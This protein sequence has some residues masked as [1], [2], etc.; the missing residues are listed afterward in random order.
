MSEH[1]FSTQS[2]QHQKLDFQMQLSLLTRCECDPIL[3]IEKWL[4]AL[5]FNAVH[6][7][8]FRYLSWQNDFICKKQHICLRFDLSA[9]VSL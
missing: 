5:L 8:E 4:P 2:E 6:E 7:L 1:S 3:A 9:P